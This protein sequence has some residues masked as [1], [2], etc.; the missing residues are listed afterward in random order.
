MRK[1]FH[2]VQQQHDSN[3]AWEQSQ[4]RRL[5]EFRQSIIMMYEDENSLLRGEDG[6]LQD[7]AAEWIIDRLSKLPLSTWALLQK[8]LNYKKEDRMRSEDLVEEVR[9]TFNLAAVA[10]AASTPSQLGLPMRI[11]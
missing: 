6:A 3:L 2:V 10:A 1:M 7:D 8:L 5:L 4:Q 11:N 9:Q